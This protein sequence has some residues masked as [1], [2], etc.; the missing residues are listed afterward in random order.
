M[1]LIP[2]RVSAR[3]VCPKSG[4]ADSKR[5]DN[6]QRRHSNPPAPKL[7]RF[8]LWAAGRSRARRSVSGRQNVDGGRG[9]VLA[10]LT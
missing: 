7:A 8:L 1:Q 5:D 4:P 9:A 2:N 6:E 10:L 3:P